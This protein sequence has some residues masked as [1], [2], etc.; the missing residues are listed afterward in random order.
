M[1][2]TAKAAAESTRIAAQAQ[3]EATRLA[4]E[5]EADATRCRAKTDTDVSDQFA[6]EMEMRRIEVSR[7]HAFGSKVSG[8]FLRRL[9]DLLTMYKDDFR[10]D[11]RSRSPGWKCNGDWNGCWHGWATLG[12]HREDSRIGLFR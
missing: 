10:A 6:R 1:I 7:V 12:G 9:S 4:A 11:R 8:H 5:A 2:A 3:A